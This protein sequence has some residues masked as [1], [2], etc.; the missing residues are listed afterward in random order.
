MTKRIMD[1][2]PGVES[3]VYRDNA[4]E[5]KT[6]YGDENKMDYGDFEDVDLEITCNNTLLPPPHSAENSV[7]KDTANMVEFDMMQSSLPADSAA[8]ID[9][10]FLSSAANWERG[11]T[12]DISARMLK[13]DRI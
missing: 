9:Q 5:T 6:N 11:S 4:G 8:T 12:R 10:E 3:I 7:P 13:V 1:T 2:E